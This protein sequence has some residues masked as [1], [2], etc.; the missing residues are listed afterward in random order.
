MKLKFL[1]FALI[2][3]IVFLLLSMFT[4]PEDKKP[5]ELSNTIKVITQNSYTVPVLLKVDI[6]ND[7]KNDFIFNTCDNL[8]IRLEWSSDNLKFDNCK[9][10]IIKSW[11]TNHVDY[12]KYFNS[13]KETWK[14]SVILKKDKIDV[15]SQFEV[16]YKWFITKLF[17][18]IFYTPIYNLMIFLLDITNYSLWW[19]IIIITIILRLVLLVPQH[20]M[21]I[22]QR[23]MQL[24][25]PKVKEIQDKYK[26]NNQMLWVELMKLYKEEKVN[27][28][29]SCWLLLIQMPLLIVIYY[30]ILEIQNS[31]NTYYLYSFLEWFN[32]SSILDNFYNID[33]YE[34]WWIQ[35]L[36][37][38]LFV[39]F[40]QYIQ[41]KLSLSYNE[42]PK[43]DWL[44]LEK[45]SWSDWYNSFMPDPEL[46]NKF[47]LYAMPVM[48]AIATFTLHAW[49]G[50]YFLIGTI[51]M[52]VQQLIVNK[53]LK[54]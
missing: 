3:L 28:M 41:I 47:M 49:L 32:V 48:I 22:S 38:A 35:W 14:Y 25:Q 2:F 36:I 18:T 39:W 51:F 9:N 30:V 5:K 1:D 37:L 24:I 4:S 27:P 42:T 6:Q 54:K 17:T 40:V 26:W 45:K 43:K 23:K 34:M 19:S 53:I 11:V 52:I 33:L 7:T 50:L 44:V 20:K 16:E 31:V 15:I 29:W 13:F 8:E 46:M 12:S 21:M 10:V